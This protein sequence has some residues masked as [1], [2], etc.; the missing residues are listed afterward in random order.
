MRCLCCRSDAPDRRAPGRGKTWGGDV[1]KASP[2]SHPTGNPGTAPLRRMTDRERCDRSDLPTLGLRIGAF[3]T[4]KKSVQKVQFEGE[5]R[6]SRYRPLT[7][8]I[9][10]RTQELHS[11]SDGGQ[12][13]ARG[14]LSKSRCQRPGERQSTPAAGHAQSTEAAGRQTADDAGVFQRTG[15]RSTGFDLRLTRQERALN[16]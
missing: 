15:A 2:R 1:A 6:G 8:N 12:S 5:L 14:R 3:C 4:R 9:F 10:I 13:P 16:T 11:A 7:L